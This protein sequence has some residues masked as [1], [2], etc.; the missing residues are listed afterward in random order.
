MAAD[1]PADKPADTPE[2]TPENTPEKSSSEQSPEQV[3]QQVI[4]QVMAVVADVPVDEVTLLEDRARVVRKG[5][6]ELGAGLTRLRIEGV[7]PVL[8]DKT[9]T[10]DVLAGP[11]P[12]G[13]P[14]GAGAEF[15]D[16]QVTRRLMVSYDDPGRAAAPDEAALQE[17]LKEREVEIK[18]LE[19]ETA[20]LERHAGGLDKIAQLTYTELTE[21]VSWGR[22]IGSQWSQRI[23]ELQG[24]EREA[25]ERALAVA[26]ELEDRKRDRHRLQLRIEQLHNPPEREWATIEAVVSAKRAGTYTL[27]FDYMVPGACWRPYHSAQLFEADRDDDPKGAQKEDGKKDA[28]KDAKKGGKKGGEKSGEKGGQDSARLVFAS[29]ACVWQ[30]TGEDWNDVQLIFSTERASLGT[31]P[32]TLTSDML[33]VRR[34]SDDV[35]V[36]ARQQEIQTAGLGAG[37]GATREAPELPGID[38]GGVVRN[39]RAPSRSSVPADGRPYR[40]AISSFESPATVELVAMPELVECVLTKSVQE[41]RGEVPLLAGPVDLIRRSGLV[42]RTQV[43]YVAAGEKFEIGWGPEPD[44]RIKRTTEVT[45]DKSRLLSSWVERSHKVYLMLSNLGNRKHVI[46]VTERIPVSE[47]DKV[48]IQLDGDETTDGKKPDDNGFV[49]WRV[50]LAARGYERV[51]L[52]YQLKKHEDVRGI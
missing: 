17:E 20:M 35:V 44:L 42:G 39:F 49:K 25:R 51:Q 29:D 14:D 26:L 45:E 10:G 3:A 52:C 32:P 47:I 43:L 22:D 31:D 50:D 30:N 7:S 21:D 33:H 46:E 12:G 18:R 36:E 15:V 24:S 5:V 19:T 48:K 11:D 9:L 40:I 38:D 41:N 34:K 23:D 16:A 6:I 37:E 13:E 1:K 8:S 4:D 2:N 27:V 28:K